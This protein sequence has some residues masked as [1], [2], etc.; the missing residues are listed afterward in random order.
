MTTPRFTADELAAA[1]GGRWLDPAPAEVAGVS[2]DTRTIAPGS[3]FVALRGERFDGH[4]FLAEAA[5]AGA[6]AAL[7]SDPAAEPTAGARGDGAASRALPRLLV[8]DTLAALGA[9]ARHHRRRFDLPVVGVTGSNGKTTT[10]EMVAAILATRGPV[11]KTEGN[12]NNE[13]GVPLTLLRLGP[14]HRFAVVELGM[15][16]PGE[17]ARLAA[18]ALPQVGVVTNA[19]AAHLEGLGT[20]DAVADAKAELYQGLPPGGVAVANADDARMLRRAQASGRRLLTFAAGRQRRGDVVVLELLDE[21]PGGLRF[22]L[23]V[24]QREVEVALPLVGAHNAANA[25]AAACAAIALGCDDREIVRGLAAVAPVGRRLRLERLASGALLVDD[26]Y[27]ANPLSMGAALRTLAA[28]AR[29]EGGRA[30]AV[31]GDM[32]ELGAGELALHREVGA[33]AAAAGVDRLLCFGPRARDIAA[34]AVAAGLPPER[35]FHTEDVAALAARARDGLVAGDVLLVKA[36][37]GTRL[38]RLVEALGH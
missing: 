3:L 20:V 16:N 22:L 30:V 33:E 35:T 10:R 19:A 23:G 36:S 24:G 25:A 1:T 15:S 8:A 6:A 12:L 37:R 4:A 17:I 13:V 32:L 34:G 18:I 2:T 11:L 27:N 29:A 31:L 5:R 26:C 21:G 38:E 28:L 14:E 9:V 7:V